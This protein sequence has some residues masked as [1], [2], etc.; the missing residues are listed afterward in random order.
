MRRRSLVG[1]WVLLRCAVA[2]L[3]V[4]L[5]LLGPLRAGLADDALQT[6]RQDVRDAPSSGSAPAGANNSNSQWPDASDDFPLLG[7]LIGVPTA[8]SVPIWGPMTLLDDDLFRPGYFPLQLTPAIKR[9]GRIGNFPSPSGP[10]KPEPD[11]LRTARAVGRSRLKPRV[12]CLLRV[13]NL[14]Y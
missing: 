12:P 7:Y 13:T 6:L 8:V 3:A 10:C 4:V 5:F 1:V 11:I 2:G 9:I 14:L